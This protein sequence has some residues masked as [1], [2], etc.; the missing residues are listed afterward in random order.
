[1]D[2]TDFVASPVPRHEDVF[3][4][5]PDGAVGTFRL[6]ELGGFDLGKCVE[7][8][9]K[10]ISRVRPGVDMDQALAAMHYDALQCVLRTAE[11]LDDNAKRRGIRVVQDDRSTVRLADAFLRLNV[12]NPE[13]RERL[14]KLKSSM[15]DLL[16]TMV[17]HAIDTSPS[18][19]P[20]T[21]S[22]SSSGSATPSPTP[23]ES[24]CTLS[25]E[26]SIGPAPVV[27]ETAPR[28]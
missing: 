28:R 24:P 16:M 25:A 23:V 13:A 9:T 17:E 5:Y 19:K 15:I 12:F 18:A 11:P 21:P 22:T 3:V 27:T 14:G 2:N 7:D 1:M 26:S 8:W 4:K 10:L 6:R 20:T